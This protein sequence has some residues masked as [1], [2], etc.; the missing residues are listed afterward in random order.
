ML[1]SYL[2]EAYDEKHYPMPDAT[3]HEVIKFMLDMKD[4]KQKDLIPIL[5]TKGNVSKI[6]S[7]AA[8]LPLESLKPLSKFLGIPVDA[9]IP[10][11]DK[12]TAED[13]SYTDP[14]ETELKG[15]RV[16][17]LHHASLGKVALDPEPEYRNKKKGKVRR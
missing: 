17:E 14:I 12:H 9:L 11:F 3:P 13:A 6:L 4:L 15:S 16:L 7:G 1:L 8:K 10:A 5:G 2:I